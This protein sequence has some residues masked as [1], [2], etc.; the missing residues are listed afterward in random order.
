MR[1]RRRCAFRHAFSRLASCIATGAWGTDDT[2]TRDRT[3]GCCDRNIYGHSTLLYWW[4]A[5]AF[6]FVF[7]LLNAGQEKFLATAEGAKPSSALGLTYVSII[8][9]RKHCRERSNT[10]PAGRC[11]RKRK[12]HDPPGD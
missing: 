2:R 8:P 10:K 1:K 7:A 3:N 4:P 12:N 6:G 11:I 5:W 9:R